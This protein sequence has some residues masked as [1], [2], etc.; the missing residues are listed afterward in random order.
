MAAITNAAANAQGKIDKALKEVEKLVKTVAKY[1][2]STEHEKMNVTIEDLKKQLDT[3]AGKYAEA[4]EVELTADFIADLRKSTAPLR[5]ELTATLSELHT[6]AK[7]DAA[8][9]AATGSIE[10]AGKLHEEMKEALKKVER[11]VK[12]I[13]ELADIADLY[14]GLIKQDEENM[15]AKDKDIADL[16]ETIAK[17]KEVQEEKEALIEK[18]KDNIKEDKA[19]KATQDALIE[20]LKQIIEQDR[21]DKEAQDEEINKLKDHKQGLK[22][23]IKVKDG[24]IGELMKI[25]NT[26]HEQA[27]DLVPDF[28]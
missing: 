23:A 26:A 20:E 1:A 3:I 12:A 9:V 13:T 11:A 7:D 17:D 8:L 16:D 4:K 28:D 22:D 6:Q 19:D 24:T 25:I 10:H 5:E 27:H 2:G 21:K 14:T 15:A 18:L